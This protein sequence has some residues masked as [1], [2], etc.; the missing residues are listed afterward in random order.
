MGGGSGL[1][2]DQVVAISATFA[3]SFIITWVVA[4]VLDLTIGIRVSAE[5]EL[6]GLDQS[7]HAESAYQ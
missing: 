7:L 6:V 1:M 3:F 4:K 2:V 5:D